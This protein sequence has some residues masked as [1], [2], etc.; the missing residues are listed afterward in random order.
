[1]SGPDS[2]L[3][4]ANR[5]LH[6]TSGIWIQSLSPVS[7]HH[8]SRRDPPE[9]LCPYRIWTRLSDCEF[10][11][12]VYREHSAEATSSSLSWPFLS[13]SVRGETNGLRRRPDSRETNHCCWLNNY[14]ICGVRDFTR[15][16]HR[17]KYYLHNWIDYTRARWVKIPKY[18]RTSRA[19]YLQKVS[20][21]SGAMM[22]LPVMKRHGKNK[23]RYIPCQSQKIWWSGVLT[24]RCGLRGVD[25]RIIVKPKSEVPKS[26]V[27]KSRP[28]G[29]GL[30]LK[31]HGPPTPPPPPPPPITFKHEGVLW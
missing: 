13:C 18:T 23:Q 2:W 17:D 11:L 22:I 16:K 7:G 3:W 29:L 26:K 1:M 4:P 9:L 8:E 28:K 20:L 27:P 14:Y 12:L 5:V 31:S 30:T 21:G 6:K 15:N 24:C 19:S 10:P 25:S